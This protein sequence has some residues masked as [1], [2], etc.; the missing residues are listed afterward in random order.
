METQAVQ[1]ATNWLAGIMPKIGSWVFGQVT[2][3]AS[4]LGVFAGLALVYAN[5]RLLLVGDGPEEARLREHAVALGIA[6]RVVFASGR[7]G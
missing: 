4:W 2:K 1:S 7:A 5:A 3:V 6:D